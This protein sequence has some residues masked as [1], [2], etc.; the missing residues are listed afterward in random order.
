MILESVEHG[1][2]IWPTIEENGVTMT[3]KIAELSA[4]EKLQANCDM[5][6]INIILQ[7]LHTTNFDQIYAYLE[8]HELHANEVRLMR[9]RNQDPLALLANHQMTPPY[10]NTYQSS[11]NNP[12]FQQQFSPSQSHQYGSTHPTQHYSTTYPSTPHAI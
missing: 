7:D 9:E 8:Q 3:K 10:F 12:Q 5:K 4:T 11:Y 1:P 2:F 6:A